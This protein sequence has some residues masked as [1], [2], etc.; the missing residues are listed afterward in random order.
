MAKSIA[1]AMPLI[2][3]SVESN[4]LSSL[5]IKITL[6]LNMPDYA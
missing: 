3:F 6:L 4:N 2:G 1:K 5:E